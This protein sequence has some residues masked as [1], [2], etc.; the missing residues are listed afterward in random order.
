MHKTNAVASFRKRAGLSQEVLAQRLNLSRPALA[1]LEAGK[2]NL[3]AEEL[4]RLSEIFGV[5]MASLMKAERPQL[6][7]A[8]LYRLFTEEA[9]GRVAEAECEYGG[10]ALAARPILG[11]FQRWV[12][13]WVEVLELAEEEPPKL[14]AVP[15]VTLG[16]AVPARALA[17]W[18]RYECGLSSTAPIHNLRAVAES[19]LNVFV[20]L[21]HEHGSPLS[22]ASWNSS[23]A[24][25]CVLIRHGMRE[26]MR[27][28][29]AHEI[30]HLFA[31]PGQA[32]GSGKALPHDA[33]RSQETYANQF[34]AELLMPA[35]GVR[36][37]V[38]GE[39]ELE[40]HRTIQRLAWYFQVS[41]QAIAIR[42]ES[43]RFLKRGWYDHELE[44]MKADGRLPQVPVNEEDL[45][46]RPAASDCGRSEPQPA[47][48][49]Y[50]A[51]MLLD[52]GDISLGKFCQLM[53]KDWDLDRAD[54]YLHRFR[55]AQVSGE[56]E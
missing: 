1:A 51:T 24:G 2:R 5:P 44:R 14:P 30:A 21:S 8:P 29:L 3:K 40:S 32:H 7:F 11:K 20:F 17:D 56:Q 4:Y 15:E 6:D 33:I 28:T 42:L 31:H 39:S 35:D 48:F 27:F 13:R 49:K 54:R 43:M 55:I 23:A 37:M 38:G 10:A 34:A 18:V 46:L 25:A 41:F 19:G 50:Y 26:H 12:E 36:K 47:L 16:Q 52:E 22:G 53:G 9:G 45:Q